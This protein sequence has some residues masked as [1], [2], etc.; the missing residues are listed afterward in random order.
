MNYL[1][2]EQSI[3]NKVEGDLGED[4][5]KEPLSIL[6][7]S[8]SNEAS[9]NTLGK[10]AL[11]F[12]IVNHLRIRSRIYKFISNNNLQRPA[13][14]IFV[15]GLPRSGTTS[16]FKLL[17]EDQNH[18]SPLVWEMFYPF[19]LVTRMSRQYKRR[20]KKTDLLMYIER[21][22][23][24]SLDSI[25]P[26]HSTDPEECL[27]ITAFS[28]R[29]LIYSYMARIPR[30]EDFLRNCDF[31]PTY[32]WH[33]RFIQVLESQKRPQRWLFKDPSHI[34]HLSEILAIYPDACFI[35]I[36][37]DPAESIPS[38]CS[39]SLKTR[40]PF[41]RDIDKDEIGQRTL[42][43]WEDALKKG[44]NKRA[45]I[46]SDQFFDLSFKDFI[47]EP[48][49]QI[50]SIYSHFGFDLDKQTKNNMISSIQQASKEDTGTHVYSL[51]EFGLSE[52]SVQDTLSKYLK[53]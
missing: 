22:L 39:L 47:D 8:L 10:L 7:D 31:T 15:I 2:S 42:Q 11:R 6:I 21:K 33:S 27:L 29:S 17:S 14:P 35:Q 28:L 51:A 4:D 13:R 25:H 24:P 18:R 1:L 30:Y 19:P 36:H 34:G 50:E 3:L 5:Y 9:L 12:Q 23:M 49:K 45:E 26:I 44:M 32:L 37:R 40:S 16:L 48:I 53:Y 20:L 52:K 38:I 41:S 43:F 46:S